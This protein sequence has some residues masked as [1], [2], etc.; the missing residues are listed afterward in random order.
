MECMIS[1]CSS[2]EFNFV[3]RNT[4]TIPLNSVMVSYILLFWAVL[5]G[6]QRAY[7]IEAW[8]RNVPQR[9]VRS[10]ACSQQYQYPAEI[11]TGFVLFQN[12]SGN[13]GNWAHPFS[14]K[15]RIHVQVCKAPQK[16]YECGSINVSRKMPFSNTLLSGKCTVTRGY[17]WKKEDVALTVPT[18]FT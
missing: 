5:H 7:S 12:T 6:T 17:H 4:N 1:R 2:I 3:D 8:F 16:S 15:G 14:V 18:A 13:H 9:T 11:S 10:R